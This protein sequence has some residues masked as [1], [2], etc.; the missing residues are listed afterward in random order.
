MIEF[1]MKEVWDEEEG[2]FKSYVNPD[3]PMA[4]AGFLEDELSKVDYD[5]IPF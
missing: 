1:D 2:R 4:Q 5:D 3:G